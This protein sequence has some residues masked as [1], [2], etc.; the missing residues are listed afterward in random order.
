[1]ELKIY[2][3]DFSKNELQNIFSYYVTNASLKV[4]NKIISE[5]TNKILILKSQPK[6]GQKEELLKDRKGDFRYL[7]NKNYKIIYRVKIESIEILDV[8]DTRQNPK[9]MKER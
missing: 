4:A 5:I 8:F 1:M 6:I 3:T 2:W 7:V 9:K